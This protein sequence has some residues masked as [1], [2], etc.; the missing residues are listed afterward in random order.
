M[1]RSYHN[2][3]RVGRHMRINGFLLRKKTALAIS[4]AVVDM[5]SPAGAAPSSVASPVSLSL[6]PYPI[7]WILVSR[8]KP[9]LSGRRRTVPRKQHNRRTYT[10]LTREVAITASFGTR[11]LSPRAREIYCAVFESWPVNLK[12]GKGY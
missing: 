8:M 6:R 4:E 9:R 1:S 7:G 2:R 12:G 3:S 10:Q 11:H 5:N